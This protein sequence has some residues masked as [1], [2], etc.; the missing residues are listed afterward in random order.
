MKRIVSMLLVVLLVASLATFAN[1]ETAKITYCSWGSA[2]EKATEE[3]IVA[4]F[5]AANP[6]VEVEYIH[7]DG[8]YEEKLQIMIAG[9][10]APDVMSIGAA[11]IPSFAS[12]F[13][14]VDI[15]AVDTGK[16]ISETLYESL[17][18]DGQQYA[19]PKRVNTKVFA[20]NKDLLT[21]ANVAFPGNEYSIEQFTADAQAVAALGDDIYGSDPL[22]FGQWLFQFGGRMLEAD[23][24]VA[25]NSE[26][27]KKAAQYIID[28]VETYAF[29]PTATEREGQDVMQWFI[30]GRVGFKGD[31]GP[32]FLPMMA[33]VT[34]FEWDVCAAPGNGGE[35]EIV[36]VGISAKTANAEAAQRLA[37]YI[38]N[39]D[40]A[41]A[42]VGGTSALPVIEAGKTVFLAQYPEKNL[43]AFFDAMSTQE[44]P[45]MIKGGN[46]V[47]GI[48]YGQLFD[49]TKLG[50][51]GEEDVALVLDEAASE[52]AE[53]LSDIQ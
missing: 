35:M 49:R 4:A 36:G 16:Y 9:D 39:A 38:S 3:A 51:S 44:I 48:L 2:E 21:K 22:W 18:F 8:N 33:Q 42:I 43:N 29:V 28:A 11:H 1:A 14:P 46:Q 27:G 47:G 26:V 53:M 10:E 13:A 25:F 40:D 31:F 24:T 23:G 30:G 45:P 7:V 6:D 19:Y 37:A 41:Q 32:Y 15:S 34:G 12:A 5:V 50:A 20:Y 52:V 17:V